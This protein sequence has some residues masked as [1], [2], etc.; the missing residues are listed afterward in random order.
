MK[1]SWNF[2]GE[3]GGGETKQKTY[4]GS[5]DIFMEL[6]N[7]KSCFAG[8]AFLPPC[9]SFSYVPKLAPHPTLST[10]EGFIWASRQVVT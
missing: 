5:M 9:T 2:L 1:L 3:G 10:R 8:S 7:R 6:H 4:G